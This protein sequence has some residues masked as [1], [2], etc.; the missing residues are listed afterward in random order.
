M[1]YSSTQLQNIAKNDPE[2]LIKIIERNNSNVA[3]LTNAIEIL[4]EEVRD[5]IIMLPVFRRLLK[6][7][8]A[9]VRESTLLAISFFYNNNPPPQDIIDKM[10]VIIKSDPSSIVRDC[11]QDILNNFKYEN[12][13]S[14]Q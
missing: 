1:N 13:K 14:N 4:G 6:H 12:S 3:I 11:C 2:E 8:H 9:Q 7:I 10:K 5:E